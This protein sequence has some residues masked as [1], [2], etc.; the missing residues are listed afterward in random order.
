MET[1]TGTYVLVLKNRLNQAVKIG[2]WATLDLSPGYYLYIGSAFGPGGVFS[3][4]A[5]HCRKDK[6]THWHIDFLR[7]KTTLSAVWVDHSPFRLE[8]DWAKGV[9]KMKGLTPV[10]GFG[11]SDCQCDA[12]LFFSAVKPTKDEFTTVT[13][14]SVESW[15][16]Q[17]ILQRVLGE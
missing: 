8:H 16:C 9:A 14:S 12:H 6:R 15:S 2:Q 5:R 4:V 13:N 11:C 1:K 17:E 3:R 10:R 7:E